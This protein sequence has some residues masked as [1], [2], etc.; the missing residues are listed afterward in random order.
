MVTQEQIESIAMYLIE[1]YG[2]GALAVARRKA[3]EQVAWDNTVGSLVWSRIRDALE[4]LAPE[5]PPTIH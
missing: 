5:P 1:R 4:R 3:A 2:I